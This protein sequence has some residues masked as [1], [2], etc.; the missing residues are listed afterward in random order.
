MPKLPESIDC[1]VIVTML[2]LWDFDINKWECT[3]NTIWKHVLGEDIIMAAIDSPCLTE[4]E[5]KIMLL[6]LTMAKLSNRVAIKVSDAYLL[7]KQD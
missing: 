4:D 1:N 3:I 6:W 7:S 2:N 5:I